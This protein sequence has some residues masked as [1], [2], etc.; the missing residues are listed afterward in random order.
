MAHIL[1]EV[2]LVFGG[3]I[4]VSCTLGSMGLEMLL[5]WTVEVE[6]EITCSFPL[7]A[8][9]VL[10]FLGWWSGLNCGFGLCIAAGTAAWLGQ[11]FM[12]EE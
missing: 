9:V 3:F 8:T 4:L 2:L 12:Y 10:L 5:P 7:D 6:F 1:L 11:G